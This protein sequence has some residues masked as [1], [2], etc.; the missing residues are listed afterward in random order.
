MAAGVQQRP[1]PFPIYVVH[2]KD[3]V[4]C[5]VADARA[6]C[7]GAGARLCT[8]AELE[9]NEAAGTGCGLDG[10][11]V[12]SSTACEVD[13]GE[14]GD[15]YFAVAGSTRAG[16]LPARCTRATA[17]SVAVRCCAD[18]AAECVAEEGAAG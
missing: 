15:G 18:V 11:R 7:A 14:E 3:D 16:M 4:I 1:H 13:T 2:G 10:K 9:A 5:D 17:T 12:W 8:R 6:L